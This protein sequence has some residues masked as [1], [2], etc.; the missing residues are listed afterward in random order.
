MVLPPLRPRRAPGEAP[1]R[2]AAAVPPLARV[3]PPAA[4]GGGAAA[5]VSVLARGDTAVP[6]PEALADLEVARDRGS[7]A[8]RGGEP[9]A[10][11][12]PGATLSRERRL[13]GAARKARAVGRVLPPRAWRS[14]GRGA[15]RSRGARPPPGPAPARAGG[16]RR[17]LGFDHPV[18]RRHLA[19]RGDRQLPRPPGGR[20]TWYAWAPG[21]PRERPGRMITCGRAAAGQA[22][23]SSSTTRSK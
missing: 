5:L 3:L 12:A 11:G 23:A 9:R 15:A 17:R 22:S 19:A 4:A 18:A 2:P 7:R 13:R 6:R 21:W 20:G 8:P 10:R 1:R 16:L 14:C